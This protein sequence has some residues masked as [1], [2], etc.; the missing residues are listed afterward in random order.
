MSY[1]ESQSHGDMQQAL[2]M[3]MQSAQEDDILRETLKQSELAELAAEQEKAE[4]RAEVAKIEQ[5]YHKQHQAAQQAAQQAA[6]QAA[7]LA[8]AAEKRAAAGAARGCPTKVAA[9]DVLAML[10]QKRQEDMNTTEGLRS[11]QAQDQRA[12]ENS[13]RLREQCRE[14]KQQNLEL[15]VEELLRL[16]SSYAASGKLARPLCTPD[17]GHP[18]YG[19]ETTC[20]NG[21]CLTNAIAM[22]GCWSHDGGRAVGMRLRQELQDFVAQNPFHPRVQALSDQARND[23]LAPVQPRNTPELDADHFGPLLA[24]MLQTPI[25]VIVDRAALLASNAAPDGHDAGAGTYAYFPHDW[26]G[27]IAERAL[28]GNLENMPVL[29]QRPGHFSAVRMGNDV[30]LNTL[31]RAIVAHCHF[32]CTLIEAELGQMA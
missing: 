31:A 28:Q 12:R 22:R 15:R 10:A 17:A 9:R 2:A 27:N 23:I 14:A 4:I 5:A 18:A 25:V 13:E 20:G 6:P 26:H 8:S 7:L 3:S 21:S 19:E 29:V 11:K 16:H 1:G 24:T 32:Q 30:K